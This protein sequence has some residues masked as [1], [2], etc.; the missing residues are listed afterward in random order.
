VFTR[1][2]KG[3]QTKQTILIDTETAA[4]HA[5][6]VIEELLQPLGIQ[7]IMPVVHILLVQLL[8]NAAFCQSVPDMSMFFPSS[9]RPRV[10]QPKAANQ[11][12]SFIA[13]D[14]DKRTH[15][16]RKGASPKFPHPRYP[17]SLIRIVEVIR[18][19]VNGQHGVLAGPQKQFNV[20][21]GPILII[22]PQARKRT[23]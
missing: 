19:L 10:L 7:E 23:P 11:P 3:Q 16:Q 15:H 20:F 17:Q 21:R 22:I 9:P 12:E 14:D 1:G 5:Y 8:Q 13:Q 4:R 6:R 2:A 18:L